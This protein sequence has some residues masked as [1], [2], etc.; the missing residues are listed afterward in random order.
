MHNS[1][2]NSTKLCDSWIFFTCTQLSD[3]ICLGRS[4]WP[5]PFPIGAT[6]ILYKPIAQR[7]NGVK[8]HRPPRLGRRQHSN[9]QQRLRTGFEL[10][11]FLFLTQTQGDSLLTMTYIFDVFGH[12]ILVSTNKSNPRPVQFAHH[13]VLATSSR[14]FR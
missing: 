8:H 1:T 3:Q 12:H 10:I 9:V 7:K 6:T 2:L 13:A 4:V 11:Q 14:Y 5:S